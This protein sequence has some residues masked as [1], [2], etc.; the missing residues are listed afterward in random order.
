MSGE[1]WVQAARPPKISA[2]ET[3]RTVAFLATLACS[4]FPPRHVSKQRVLGLAVGQG[5]NASSVGVSMF[6]RNAAV[7][8]V[9]KRVKT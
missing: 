7:P 8:G 5:R 6:T 3:P 4:A 1:W 2:P 9:A